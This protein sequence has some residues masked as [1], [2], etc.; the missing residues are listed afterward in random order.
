[1]SNRTGKAGEWTA[2][3]G[4]TNTPVEKI[5]INAGDTIDFITD[6]REHHTSDS[7]NWPVTITLK[8]DGQKDQAIVAKDQFQGPLESRDTLPGQIVKAWELA[9]C[10][11]PEKE[12][13]QLAVEFVS[14]QIS[15]FQA[16]RTALPGNRRPARQ[17]II[18]L[19]QSLMSSNEF[20]Y[21]D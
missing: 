20:L 6:C 3:N 18:D 17:A 9:L 10:R 4:A 14:R 1:M 8:R 5:D 16:A 2:F 13:L 12:E 11:R 15:T 19:C 21:V 7:F